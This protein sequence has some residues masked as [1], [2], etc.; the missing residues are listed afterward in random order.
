VIL[1]WGIAG[2][3]PLR[4]VREALERDGARVRFLDQ[5][6]VLDVAVDLELDA[7]AR[8]RGTLHLPDMAV[9]LDAIRSVY[10]RPYDWRRF[11][12][13]RDAG[14]SSPAWL[15]AARIDDALQCWTELTTAMVVNRPSA[16]ASNGSKPYQA[17]LIRSFGLD[18]PETLVT[19]DPAAALEFWRDHD[20][21]VY[22]SISGVRSVVSRLHRAHLS[23]LRD[24]AS[25]PTQFQEHI[26]GLDY[27]LHIVGDDLFAS[28]IASPADDYRYASRSGAGVAVRPCV[29]PPD[30]VDR[31]VTLVSSMG[32]HF[33]GVDLR[34]TPSGAWYCFEVNPSPGFSY[35]EEA[36]GQP[37]SSAVARLLGS[38]FCGHVYRRA[39]PG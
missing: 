9:D 3:A 31:C 33:A 12:R 32:L 34:R 36:T 5:Q 10:V 11:Q 39:T 4:L 2:D 23:R 7:G 25:C 35:Y 18:T 1:L 24:V 37:I 15:H 6:Q 27:R 14:P 26:A 17:A 30:V 20:A 29:L 28:E 16:M 19:T 13:L 8:I 38:A 22:K 21:V